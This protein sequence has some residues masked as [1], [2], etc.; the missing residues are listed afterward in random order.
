[1]LMRLAVVRSAWV[2]SAWVRSA[3]IL[4]L[5]QAFC[6]VADA[7][8]QADARTV[9]CIGRLEPMGGVIQ[10]SGPSGQGAVIAELFVAEG[11]RVAAGQ[12]LAILDTY[13][14]RA[15]ERKRLEA[16]L[17]NAQRE[18]SRTRSLASDAAVSDARRD[19]AEMVARVA[20]AR[21]EAA[22]ANLEMAVGRAPIDGQVLEVHAHAGERVAREGVLE[23]GNTEAMFAVAEVYE[24]EIGRVRVGQRAVITSPALSAPVE[25]E[26]E[27]IGLK[28][29]KMDLFDTDPVARTD[30]RVVETRIRLESGEEVSR[31]TNLQVDVEIFP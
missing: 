17:E 30:A 6:V 12:K 27:R 1:M 28:V 3:A 31:L 14:L 11:D 4:V 25:G 7:R 9:T 22:G 10:V 26:V 13:A 23:L 16:E 19:E 20:R 29:G 24:T 18:L 15:A 2:R 21:L 5:L 8:A